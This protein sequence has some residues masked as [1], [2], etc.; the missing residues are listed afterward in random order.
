MVKT[1]QPLGEEADE[2]DRMALAQAANGNVDA[3]ALVVAHHE[4]RL[5]GLCGRMLGN[6]DAGRDAAQETFLKAFRKAGSYRPNGR[7]FTWLYR[8][9]VNH[10]LNQL[11]RRRIVRFLSLG[12]RAAANEHPD[13]VVAEPVEAGPGPW[14]HVVARR[15]WSRVRSA[16]DRLPPG[17]RAVL[18]LAKFEG[19]RYREI[20]QV[21]EITE[22]AVESR[23]FRA[24][25]RLAQEKES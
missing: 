12:D 17:Q 6:V 14:R 22:G 9:A 2:R 13:V 16:I 21:L 18:V 24:M 1:E 10:C 20:A 19:L 25:R 11:R 8:I 23:L 4:K 3:F 15:R 7:V 5:I